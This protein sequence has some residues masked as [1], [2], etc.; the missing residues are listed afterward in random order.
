MDSLKKLQPFEVDG[1]RVRAFVHLG[2]VSS[3]GPAISSNPRWLVEINNVQIDGGLEAHVDDTEEFVRQ[4]VTHQV[5]EQ[6]S[7]E[8]KAARSRESVDR[9]SYRQTSRRMSERLGMR[10]RL[11]HSPRR[12]SRKSPSCPL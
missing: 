12:V 6:L 4:H 3:S 9:L 8:R 11:S 2:N 10:L 5:R 1:H 7:Q